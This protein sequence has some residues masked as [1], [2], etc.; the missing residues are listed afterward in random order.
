MRRRKSRNLCPCVS[1]CPMRK[2]HDKGYILSLILFGE[3]RHGSISMN[4]AVQYTHDI[5]WLLD[6]V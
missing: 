2:V 3:H 6:T 4:N 1:I 5:F